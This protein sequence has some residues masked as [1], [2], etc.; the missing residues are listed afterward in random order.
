MRFRPQCR[1]IDASQTNAWIER[2][3]PRNKKNG[4]R[5]RNK[6]SKGKRKGIKGKEGGIGNLVQ[7]SKV[8]ID[9]Q[10]GI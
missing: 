7:E 2:K 5:G 10:D 6:V 1:K 3:S 4:R 9:T 8:R